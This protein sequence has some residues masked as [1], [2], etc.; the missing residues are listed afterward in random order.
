MNL[1]DFQPW[2]PRGIRSFI[3]AGANRYVASFDKT[4][5]LKFPVV[6]REERMKYLGSYVWT[7]V[8]A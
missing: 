3:A 1:Y 2:Y 8:E 6:L 5:V 4:T 7:D